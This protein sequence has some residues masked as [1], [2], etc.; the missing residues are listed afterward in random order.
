MTPFVGAVHKDILHQISCQS[1]CSIAV[2]HAVLCSL[3]VANQM[4]HDIPV[5]LVCHISLRP[6]ADVPADK[7]HKLS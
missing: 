5:L 3:Q 6:A 4:L 7:V 2:Q 1:V